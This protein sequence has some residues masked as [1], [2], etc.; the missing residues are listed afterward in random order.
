MLD[1][2]LGGLRRLPVRAGVT[3]NVATEDLVYVLDE[4]GVATGVDLER[5]LAAS[6]WLSAQLGRALPSAVYAPAASPP[7]TSAAP[8]ERT[9]ITRG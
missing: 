9:W 5:A 3:G 6:A 8:A 2:S 7:A 4:M 1:T